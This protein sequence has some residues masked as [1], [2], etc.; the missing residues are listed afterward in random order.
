MKKLAVRVSPIRKGRGFVKNCAV[1][2]SRCVPQWIVN[3]KKLAQKLDRVAS[4]K[5]FDDNVYVGNLVCN[6][7]MNNILR[8]DF[9]GTPSLYEFEDASIYG[10]E[11][12]EG[13]LSQVF[14]D[15][16]KLPP[17]DKQVSLH[18]STEMDLNKSYL[19]M[20]EAQCKR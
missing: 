16:R 10:A 17:E 8:R 2:L 19:D 1:A 3:D 18:L 13:Y 6:Y 14:G 11:D 20:G 12:Y 15:W 4:E 5:D 7:K 9:F